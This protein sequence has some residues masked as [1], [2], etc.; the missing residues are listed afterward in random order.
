MKNLIQ[1]CGEPLCNV[2]DLGRLALLADSS[3]DPITTALALL[4]EAGLQAKA[5]ERDAAVILGG[6]AVS[7]TPMGLIFENTFTI[8]PQEAGF[9]AVVTGPGNLSREWPAASRQAAASRVI[10]EYRAR[11]VLS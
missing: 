1:V 5:A 7:D 9:V 8:E 4:H 11:G 10:E 6:T 2:R 3:D